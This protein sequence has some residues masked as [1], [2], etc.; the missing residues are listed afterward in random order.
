MRLKKLAVGLAAFGLLATASVSH[1]AE[2]ITL[3]T[4]GV[5]G[6][7]YPVGGA[8]CRLL[9][10]DAKEHGLRCRVESTGGSVYNINTIR[11]GELDVAIAQS[12]VQ[13]LSY[14]GKGRFEKSG[15]FKELRSIF[16]VH[17][18]AV[19]IIA[20][21]DANV[22]HVDDLVGKRVNIGNPGSGTEAIWS[23]M[24]EA[25]GK[26]NDDLGLVSQMK[27]SETPAALCDNKVDAVNW[28]AGHPLAGA[29]EASTTCDVVMVEVSGPKIDKLV[30]DNAYF[31]YA[32]IPAGMYQGTPNA[33]KTFGVGAV[34]VTSTKTPVETVY[35][36]TKAIFENFDDFK[37]LH[38]ALA[39]LT[40][41]EMIEN[42]M[43]SPLHEGAIKYYKEKGLM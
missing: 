32:T 19:T 35:H 10:K 24:W 38:P 15:P 21:K 34:F 11:A 2:F 22:S 28:V 41:K 5:T 18:E 20:R 25:L 36:L 33:T 6:V 13:W 30:K 8:I 17:P 3:G 12:D 42:A 40:K 23:V 29:K 43:S 4:G 7:Y 37:R 26:S 31:R 9:N 39:R 27:S 14:N 16:A 1:A